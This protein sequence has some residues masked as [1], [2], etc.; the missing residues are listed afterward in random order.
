MLKSTPLAK[1]SSE[2][3]GRFFGWVPLHP[4]TITLFSVLFAIAGFVLFFY[5]QFISGFIFFLLAFFLDAVDGAVARAKNL[6]SKKGAFLDGISD[7]LVEFLLILA[8]F[9]SIQG[10]ANQLLLVTIL[11]FGTCM[12]AFVKAYAEHSGLLDNKTAKR[13]PGLLER[14]ERSVLLLL[15][16]LLMLLG[17]GSLFVFL[18]A[19]IALLSAVTFFQRVWL[20]MKIG[21]E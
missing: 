17:L 13:M 18:L 7:R 15:A 2:S 5:S 19:A 8:L 6:T 11:F 3:L 21:K 9:V 16:P 20:T 14:A 10:I 12:T 1:S 4:N